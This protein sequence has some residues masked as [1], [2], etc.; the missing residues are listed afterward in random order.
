M[1]AENLISDEEMQA[2][3]P[4][5]LVEVEV[6]EPG[7]FVRVDLRDVLKLEKG[8][9]VTTT[10]L[11]ESAEVKETQ[12]GEPFVAY[13]LRDRTGKV[14]AKHWDTAVAIE[15]G[16]VVKIRAEVNLYRD[17][18][19]LK[20]DRVRVYVEANNH[21][22]YVPASEFDPS[23]LENEFWEIVE[24]LRGPHGRFV[25]GFLNFHWD[26]TQKMLDAPAALTYHHA[27]WHGLLEHTVSMCLLA[28]KICSH[29]TSIYEDTLD[30]ELVVCGVILHDFAKALDQEWNGAQWVETDHA[31]MVGH[32]PA[33]IALLQE[34]AYAEHI[35]NTDELRN[36]QHLVAAHHGQVEFGAA[37]VPK[38]V[39]A[40]VLH[41]VDMIDSKMA[42][43]R[44][45]TE[46]LDAGE[47]SQWSRP[48]KSEFRK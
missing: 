15:A 47:W 43:W 30:E 22:E 3:L 26:I 25:K 34:Y 23:E 44:Q 38:T 29:Y 35:R 41:H 27:F 1:S 40:M 6:A 37:V 14:D 39:E 4:D 36:L 46:G 10:A 45:A 2:V 8:A 11:V 17:Q 32:I 20:V 13:V 9:I 16:E 33:C 31:K 19:Q 24:G 12:K 28:R 18:V 42:M 7:R 48:L 21:L 5:V